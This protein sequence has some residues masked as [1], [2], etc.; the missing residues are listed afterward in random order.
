MIL[1]SGIGALASTVLGGCAILPPPVMPAPQGTGLYLGAQN[2]LALWAPGSMRVRGPGNVESTIKGNGDVR[3]AGVMLPAAALYNPRVAV[4]AAPSPRTDLGVYADWLSAGAQLRLFER[5]PE[6]AGRRVAMSIA[7]QVGYAQP[8]A[9][10]DI[11]RPYEVR[12]LLENHPP[13][14]ARWSGVVTGGAS[15]GMRRHSIVQPGSDQIDGPPGT[16]DTVDVG[17]NETRVEMTGGVQFRP[18]SGRVTVML[19][20]SPYLIL[21]NG[22]PEGD[23][24]PPGGYRVLHYD[25]RWGLSLTV[26]WLVSLKPRPPSPGPSIR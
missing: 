7:Y 22:R 23:S 5:V 17:R 24:L 6:A 26:N 2:P 25:Q 20:L 18:S 1:S 9:L 8:E 12:L 10:T 11:P 19:A 21:S 15:Y 13:T 4:H 14:D 3:G 16:K